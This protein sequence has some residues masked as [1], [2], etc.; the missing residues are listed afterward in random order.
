MLI[1]VTGGA[2]YIGS[3][4]CKFLAEQ[5]HD[6]IIYDNLSTGWRSFAKYGKFI[7]G[8]ICDIQNLRMVLHSHH[9][10][11]V[12]HFAAKAYVA[13]SVSNPS[14]Y[15]LNNN[16]GTLSLL[17]AMRNE[18]V[19]R[20]VV[21]STC[22]VY[23]IPKSLPITESESLNPI[24]PYGDSKYFMERML[25]AFAVAY[26][27]QWVSLRYFNAAGADPEGFLGERHIPE[28]HLI[29]L[30]LAATSGK[31]APLQ[32]MGT[33]YPTV[34]GTCIRDYVHVTDLA[35][36]HAY[37][38][39]YLENGGKSISL[40]LGS[41]IGTSVREVLNTVEKVTG[42]KVPCILGPRRPSDPP[43]LYASS[44]KANKILGWNAKFSNIE[45]IV[46]TAW[47]WHIK[48]CY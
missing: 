13:E 28:T 36:A 34:D 45:D 4:T 43:C 38:L 5:G 24:S 11:A 25:S 15:F 21:S 29:P 39:D 47:N 22:A 35:R 2:G 19:S 23:G 14:L 20:I 41:G 30:A 6:V 31:G 17:E 46:E 32:I 16:Y 27:L 18:N 8:D 1:L 37:A 42:R 33:D 10:E 40:N 44:C 48:D 7:H 9:V 3:H 26:G 12:V